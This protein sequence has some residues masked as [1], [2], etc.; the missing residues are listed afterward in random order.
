MAVAPKVSRMTPARIKVVT[1]WRHLRGCD[2]PATLA[3]N[4]PNKPKVF[5]FSVVGVS[6]F[7][8]YFCWG[9]L[10]TEFRIDQN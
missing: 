5:G 6:D 10:K 1:R 7:G 8:G 4:Q 3:V 2:I 9:L